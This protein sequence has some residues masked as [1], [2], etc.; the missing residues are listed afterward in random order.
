MKSGENHMDMTI[1]KYMALVKTVELGSF[2]KAAELFN[3]SQFGISRMINDL[4]KEW[5]V[6][7][8]KRGRAGVRLTS[9]G[10]KLLP[11]A[12]NVCNDYQK[13]QTQVDELNGLQSGLI[14]IGTISSIAN[15]LAS[16]CH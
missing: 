1:Q 4:E 15:P 16:K 7:L 3:Y 14:R 9:D 6:S 13:L 10:L 8:L 11:F 12:Q 5:S 2:T